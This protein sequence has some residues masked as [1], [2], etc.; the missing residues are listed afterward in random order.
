MNLK[1]NAIYFLAKFMTQNRHYFY[2]IVPDNVC[3]FLII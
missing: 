1:L 2:A 3:N